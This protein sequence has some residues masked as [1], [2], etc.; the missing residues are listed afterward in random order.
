MNLHRH[1]LKGKHVGDIL[2]PIISRLVISR[3]SFIHSSICAPPRRMF[4]TK[5]F[6][7]TQ[8]PLSINSQ[9][10][11]ATEAQFRFCVI[12]SFVFQS[13][14]N[15]VR[16][17][18]FNIEVNLTHCRLGE[19]AISILIECFN[20]IISSVHSNVIQRI[21]SFRLGFVEIDDLKSIHLIES[22]IGRSKYC[23]ISI[24]FVKIDGE[25]QRCVNSNS[26]RSASSSQKSLPTSLT[27][28]PPSSPAVN[29]TTP[30]HTTELYP[31]S[32]PP[33]FL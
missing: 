16:D 15:S 5:F 22:Y 12:D 19:E 18:L 17:N 21:V 9:D 27:S 2:R 26:S 29:T 8:F 28:Y 31:P 32:A 14:I 23:Q 6:D 25:L 10:R 33:M 4:P 20:H 7:G 11:E 1:E 13:L 30:I 3:L 24:P